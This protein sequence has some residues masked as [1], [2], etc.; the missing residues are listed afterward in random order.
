MGRK[1]IRGG[2]A[3]VSATGCPEARDPET[4]DRR[5]R[6]VVRRVVGTNSRSQGWVRRGRKSAISR[7]LSGPEGTRRECGER[8]VRT[9]EAVQGQ[10]LTDDR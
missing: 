1:S 7:S 10:R 4:D 8:A 5:G 2:V 9:P 3:P 6:S